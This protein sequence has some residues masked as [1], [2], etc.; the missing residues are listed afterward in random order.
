ME[1]N[2]FHKECEIGNFLE[3]I[4]LISYIHQKTISIPTIKFNRMQER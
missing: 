1:G 3:I 2:V 4:K